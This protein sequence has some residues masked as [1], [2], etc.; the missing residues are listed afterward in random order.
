MEKQESNITPVQEPVSQSVTKAEMINVKMFALGIIGIIVLAILISAGIGIYRV[1]AKVST[2]TFTYTVAK[3][4]RLPAAKI[5]GTTIMYSDFVDDLKAI[6]ILRAYDI[7]NSG[8]SANLTA[9]Q[10]SDQVLWRLLNNILISDAAKNFDIKAEQVDADEIKAQIMKQFK[11]E[12]EASVALKE[13]YGW[14]MSEYENKVIKYYILQQKLSDVI[15]TDKKSRDEV[16]MQADEVLKKIQA[17]ANFEDMAKQY[18]QDGT[19]D[20]GGDLGWFGQGDMVPQFEA[21]VFTL[22]KGELGPEVI[23]SPYGFHI[24]RV[25][26]KKVEDKAEQIKARHIFFRLPSL[27]TY[28]ENTTKKAQIHLYIKAHNPFDALVVE[29]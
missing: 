15:S 20:S 1:Y 27:E 3:I 13:R 6:N 26:D 19:A 7:A 21:A 4:L 12:E 8:A 22:E 2:D 18:S 29:Q 10:M 25:D 23:E 14:T 5:N 17:G 28:L 24:V 9:E 11:N 16:F